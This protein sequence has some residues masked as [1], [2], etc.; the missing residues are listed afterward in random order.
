[1]GKTNTRGSL[2]KDVAAQETRRTEE[3]NRKRERSV[4]STRSIKESDES[5]EKSAVNFP[6]T[7][8]MGNLPKY[9]VKHQYAAMKGVHGEDILDIAPTAHDTDFGNESDEFDIPE[10]C[11]Q[12]KQGPIGRGGSGGR[13]Y[14]KKK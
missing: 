11:R 14:T 5:F 3:G 4:S 10:E 8:P 6:K 7:K 12:K 2:T 9:D 1:M 13:G